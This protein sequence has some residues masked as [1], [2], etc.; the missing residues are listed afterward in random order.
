[1][2][3]TGAVPWYRTEQPGVV[4]VCA[5]LGWA[6][7]LTGAALLL[8][9]IVGIPAAIAGAALTVA[10]FTADAALGGP[11]QPGS[12]VNS[13]PIFGLRWYG[14]GN[15]TFGAYASAGL[16][17]AG[18]VAHRFLLR[19]RQR[20][21]IAAVAL[22]GFGIVVCQ[23]WPTMGSDFGGVIALTPSVLWLIFAVSGAWITWQRLLIAVGSTVL[24]V[25]LISL[26]DWARGPDQRSHLGNF[27]QRI[28]DGDALDVV[29][30]KAVAALQ[31]LSGPLGVGIAVIGIALWVVIFKYAASLA[32]DQFSTI[33]PTLIAVL[34]C[35]ILGS[36]VNDGGIN[37]W[38]TMT[39]AT[40]VTV[41]W[42]CV[43]YALRRGWPAA[44]SMLRR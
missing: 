25:G 12:L 18:Y 2:M 5:M 27:V 24:A 19:G 41:A 35:A 31:T 33:R 8:A 7:I 43:D 44:A 9:R 1:M 26:L 29:S 37:V 15:V 34:I 4:A 32:E 14:F 21:A 39:S 23:G 42:F 40:T 38:L 16:L 13:R 3:L 10:A 6:A 17:L 11:M 22:V 36:L 28:L 20:A 30:R